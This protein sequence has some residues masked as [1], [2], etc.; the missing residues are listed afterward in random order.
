MLRAMQIGNEG[1]AAANP[2]YIGRAGPQI[3]HP[4]LKLACQWATN[5][6]VVQVKSA[7]RKSFSS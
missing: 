3:L 4:N 2:G 6:T 7:L 1:R 5:P